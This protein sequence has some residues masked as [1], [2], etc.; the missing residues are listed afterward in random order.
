MFVANI[1]LKNVEVIFV[2]CE[3]HYQHGGP[4]IMGYI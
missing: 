2:E 1:Y 4:T 3:E